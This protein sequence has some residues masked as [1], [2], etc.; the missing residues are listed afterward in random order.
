MNWEGSDSSNLISVWQDQWGDEELWEQTEELYELRIKQGFHS[1]KKR[2]KKRNWRMMQTTT[3]SIHSLRDF[4]NPSPF[5]LLCWIWS[6]DQRRG[7]RLSCHHT[8]THTSDLR[9]DASQRHSHNTSTATHTE[10]I[11]L[12]WPAGIELVILAWRLAITIKS[13]PV[14]LSDWYLKW[15]LNWCCAIFRIW[16]IDSLLIWI[17]HNTQKVGLELELEIYRIL[18][19]FWEN[20]I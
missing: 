8:H 5:V 3:E 1:N 18:Q 13:S 19:K 11:Q 7:R 6:R 20:F 16:E 2:R 12:K 9:T 15:Q 10:N 4:I 17:G 14:W